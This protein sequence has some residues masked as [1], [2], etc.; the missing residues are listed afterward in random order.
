MEVIY[1][2]AKDMFSQSILRD[3]PTAEE[4]LSGLVEFLETEVGNKRISPGMKEK[5]LEIVSAALVDSLREYQRFLH[6]NQAPIFDDSGLY[7]HLSDSSGPTV[8]KIPMS[9]VYRKIT[10]QD[11]MSQFDPKNNRPNSS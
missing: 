11:V 9:E 8:S 5:I 4:T 10:A 6:E 3:D 7:R 1:K 2:L